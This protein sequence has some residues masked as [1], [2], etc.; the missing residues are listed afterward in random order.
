[1]VRKQFS[2][3]METAIFTGNSR[4]SDPASEKSTDVS[5]ERPVNHD[6]FPQ[7][8]E[9]YSAEQK[10]LYGLEEWK[11]CLA[12]SSLP[13]Q[14]IF[15]PETFPALSGLKPVAPIETL[16]ELFDEAQLIFDQ[17]PSAERC[18]RVMEGIM[19]FKKEPLDSFAARIPP[20]AKRVPFPEWDDQKTRGFMGELY[21]D[22]VSNP[23]AVKALIC[24][25]LNINFKHHT[26]TFRQNE[27]TPIELLKENGLKVTDKYLNQK[28]ELLRETGQRICLNEMGLVQELLE[29]FDNPADLPVLS[30]PTHEGGWIDPLVFVE[31]FRKVI[32]AEAKPSMHDFILALLRLAPDH[33]QAAL[34][35]TENNNSP[36]TSIIQ[37]ALGSD[38]PIACNEE[39]IPEYWL[40]AAR[41]RWCYRP[42]PELI[43]GDINPEYPEVNQPAIYTY[44]PQ[45]NHI[46][47]REELLNREDVRIP[48]HLAN[49]I[50]SVTVRQLIYLNELQN[51]LNYRKTLVIQPQLQRLETTAFLPTV[52]LTQAYLTS[53]ILPTLWPSHPDGALVALCNQ[54]WW[55]LDE[56]SHDIFS[57]IRYRQTFGPLWNKDR[58]WCQPG[59]VAVWLGLACVYQEVKLYSQDLIIEAIHD[60][61]F[62]TQEMSE[63][64]LML[65]ETGS[66]WL[67]LKP[68]IA[69]LA[70]ISRTSPL[71][72]WVISE[73]L[74]SLIAHW[75]TPPREAVSMLEL[76]L[77]LLSN[78][79]RSPNTETIEVLKTIKGS[80]KSAKLAKQLCVLESQPGSQA[81]IEA[82]LQAYEA[83]L[84]RAER[85]ESYLEMNAN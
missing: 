14:L 30:I 29:R 79:N 11:E 27:V 4:E 60:D 63:S 50:E 36:Y 61:R 42:L 47:Y 72:E 38:I 70:E 68:I 77:E 8:I 76:L 65:L 25:W 16:E 28:E 2:G 85:V 58:N 34:K 6:R 57:C 52:R 9:K 1:M 48:D 43:F 62:P 20:I 56:K 46:T 53:S 66:D 3:K 24:R 15:D 59:Q 19:R 40:A 81:Q 78:L 83:R 32:T 45:N 51:D 73:I 75:T 41:S 54:L 7:E 49:A 13:P 31:R 37:F 39:Q 64:L 84:A 82:I 71:A 17:Y 21:D 26:D 55:Y 5:A 67:K 74:Q 44:L 35:A 18:H 10:Q 12:Q 22:Y 23:V 69:S 80:S 33:R